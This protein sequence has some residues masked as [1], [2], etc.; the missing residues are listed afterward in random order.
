M[1]VEFT[2]PMEGPRTEAA[3]K[4]VSRRPG[5]R[6]EIPD[7]V[8]P[9]DGITEGQRLILRGMAYAVDADGKAIK[10][11]VTHASDAAMAAAVE[12][13]AEVNARLAKLKEAEAVDTADAADDQAGVDLLAEAERLA[14]DEAAEAERLAQT[15][16]DDVQRTQQ[17][18]RQMS[19][20]GAE[21]TVSQPGKP[22]P[23]SN[24]PGKSK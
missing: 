20:P 3:P 9:V 8:S 10:V 1:L 7:V 6:E 23:A 13:L 12:Q 17:T 14:R 16:G 24:K 15:Q 4:G 19:A 2:C 11:T 5:D 18:E 21:R 22:A